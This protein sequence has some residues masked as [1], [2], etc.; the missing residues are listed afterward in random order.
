MVRKSSHQRM[1]PNCRAGTH[2]LALAAVVGLAALAVACAPTRTPFPSPTPTDTAAPATPT[3]HIAPSATPTALLPSATPTPTRTALPT[4]TPAATA[5]P[6]TARPTEPPTPTATFAPVPQVRSLVVSSGE[7][8]TLYAV[9]GDA[10]Y[11]SADGGA[12]WTALDI[13]GIAPESRLF[14]LALD[15]RNPSVMY[16]TTTSGIYRRVG[17]SPW[18]FVH[19]LNAQALAVDFVDSNTLWAG[20]SW[21]TE[22]RAVILKSTDAGRTWGKADFGI[23]AYLGYG[24][25]SIIIDPVNPDIL[26]ANLR[27]GGRFGWP[28]GW[29]YRGGRAGTWEPLPLGP[30]A[31]SAGFSDDACM[32]HGLAFDPTLRR[33][34]VGCDAYYYNNSRLFMLWS[35]NAHEPNAQSIVWGK[36]LTQGT[37][38]PPFALGFAAPLA[39]DARPPKAL[40]AAVSGTSTESDKPYRLLVSRDDGATWLELPLPAF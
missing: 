24:V 7:D 6:T 28:D 18:E 11:Q 29:L 14:A 5:T 4:A 2:C 39:V 21:T 13:A 20:V 37:L 34:Y 23:Q 33:L 38:T 27:Y 31:G 22:Y 1:R 8:R 30:V 16:A 26:Y 17:N 19:P 12:T 10:A 25:T 35:D 9:I 3:Q 40:Y 15:Y 32:P 36:A